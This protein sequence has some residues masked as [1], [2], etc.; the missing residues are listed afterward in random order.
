MS[1]AASTAKVAYTV[2]EAASAAGVSEAVIRRALHATDPAAW[3]PPLRSK[4]IGHATNAP[5]L[6]P[7]DWLRAWIDAFPEAS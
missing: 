4:R 6:I 3:P 2:T 5:H 1:A 7:A